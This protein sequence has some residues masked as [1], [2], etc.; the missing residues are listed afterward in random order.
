[1][2]HSSSDSLFPLANQ[3][4]L[5]AIINSLE[6]ENL[7]RGYFPQLDLNIKATYQSK[8]T[9]VPSPA[10][11][12]GG[13]SPTMPHEQYGAT[14]DIKQ[15]IYDGGSI[16]N[17]KSIKQLKHSA[18]IQEIE[19]EQ[20]KIKE[21]INQLFI[22]C[23]IVQENEKIIDLTS[24]SINEQKKVLQSSV[25]NGLINAS[26]LDNLDAELLKLDQQKIELL[27]HKKHVLSALNK[28]SC[29]NIVLNDVLELPKLN[30]PQELSVFRPEHQLF[31]DKAK[32]IDAN[33]DFTGTQ[34]M[35]KIYAFTSA[36]A[37]YPGLNMFSDQME[38]YFIIGAQLNWKIWDWKQTKR[39]KEQL[40]IQK[41]LVF[42]QQEVFDKN[43]SIQ[44]TEA[45][46]NAEKLELLIEKDNEIIALRE[47]ITMR[48]ASQLENGTITSAAYLMDLNAEKQAKINLKQRQIQL[49]QAQINLLTISGEKLFANKAIE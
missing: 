43:I 3:I 42:N 8:V 5:H 41:Q 27:S 18:N 47:K 17:A 11:A 25:D 30:L 16:K 48:S 21:R 19:V 31:L 44:L 15:I 10:G 13:S 1:M 35:P 46:L 6:I 23:L 20:Y 24:A 26:E 37:G 29:M 7:K 34:R 28:L 32:V 36:G 14:V 33:I 12:S 4:E 22:L 45:K 40:N 9:E 2:C 39:N 49:T 38:P